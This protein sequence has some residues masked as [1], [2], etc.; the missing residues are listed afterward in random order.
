QDA[1]WFLIQLSQGQG[2]VWGF[3][4]NVNGNEFNAPVV[5]PY[6]TAGNPAALTGVVAQTNAVMRLRAAP[7]VGSE[8]I[9]RVPW[10]D[11]VPVIGRSADGGWVQVVFRGTVGWLAVNFITFV[12]G[13]VNTVPITG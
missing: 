2:W 13:D 11:I 4:L 10:G 12:E 6:I 5:S 9:G 3:Y 7:L 1:R 8:Q